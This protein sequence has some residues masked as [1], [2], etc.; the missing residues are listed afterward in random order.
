MLVPRP[1]LSCGPSSMLRASLLQP[2]IWLN[3]PDEI[4]RAVDDRGGVIDL[5]FVRDYV[6]G[7]GLKDI[8]LSLEYMI[9]IVGPKGV[10]IG[11]L[12][13][14]FLHQSHWTSCRI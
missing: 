4:L 13:I 8:L 10:A 14:R 7:D 11:S 3:I 9:K 6:V 1:N 12:L 2:P 5:C